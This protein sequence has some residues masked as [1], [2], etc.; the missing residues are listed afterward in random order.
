MAGAAEKWADKMNLTV[1]EPL[2][3]KES[4]KLENYLKIGGYEAWKKILA[5]KPTRRDRHRPGEG[6]G[7]A[8]PR[9]RGIP[10][11]HEVELHAAQVAGA[12]VRGVQ[13]GRVRARHLPRPRHPALQPAFA[14]RGHG[15]RRLLHDRH[16]GLQLHPRRVPR[17]ARAALR[18][19]GEGSLCRRVVR[20]EHPGL[21]RRLRSVH[22]GRRRRLHLRRGDRAA[23]FARRQA[24]QA[25]LQAAVPGRLRPVRRADHHQQHAELRLGAHHPAQ[26]RGLV[27][28]ARR[29]ECRRHGDLLGVRPRQQA[30]QLRSA[31]GHS[32]R[33]P[34]RDCRRREGRPQAQGRDSRRLVGVR[35]ARGKDPGRE[36]GL[37]L[38][39]GRGFVGGFGR[40]HRHGRDHL[41]G[42][43]A[44]A[45]VALLQERVLRPVHAVPRRHRLDES[46]DPPDHGGAGRRRPTCSC[47]ST[48]RAASKATPSARWAMPPR[49]R[50]RASSSISATSSNT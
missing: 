31:D 8:R 43:G 25:A 10:H 45:P 35:V 20:Q 28:E 11:R 12:E 13:L 19:G 34:A 18:S 22:R 23:R 48:S 40:G 14:D 37:R 29:A 15:H 47:W 2:K 46:R 9:R 50:C 7:P 17:R 26:G 38:A 3:F 30:R 5:E 6:L 4:W 44:R 16:R 41:H 1:F 21:R 24:G 39:E 36:H 49:G 33:G 32:V 42:E 27:R